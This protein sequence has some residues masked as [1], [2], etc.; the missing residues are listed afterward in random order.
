MVKIAASSPFH[1]ASRSGILSPSRG[2]ASRAERRVETRRQR[3]MNGFTNTIKTWTLMAALA[4]LLV[5]VGGVL[6]GQ[7]GMVMAF[8]ERLEDYKQ[9]PAGGNI[10][11]GQDREARQGQHVGHR[12]VFADDFVQSPHNRVRASQACT[13]RQVRGDNDVSLVLRWHKS[14]R[15]NSKPIAGKA[16]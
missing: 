6:G 13:L 1:C 7:S 2:T 8:L 16:Q 4:G 5:A 10:R 14:R 15:S 9:R 12:L 11:A 3:E